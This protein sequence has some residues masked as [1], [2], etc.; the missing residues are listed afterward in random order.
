[1]SEIPVRI[2]I[3]EVIPRESLHAEADVMCKAGNHPIE[4]SEPIRTVRPNTARRKA[5]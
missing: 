4:T 5:A 2:E 3:D 1:M